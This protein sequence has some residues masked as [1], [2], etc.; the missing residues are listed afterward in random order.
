[1][2]S[3]QAQAEQRLKMLGQAAPIPVELPVK[4]VAQAGLPLR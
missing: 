2:P 4:P 1:M 3:Q